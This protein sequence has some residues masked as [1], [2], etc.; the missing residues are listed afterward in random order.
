MPEVTA[1]R[2]NWPVGQRVARK[3]SEDHGTVT[4]QNGQIR[5]RWDD[6]RTSYFRH[7]RMANVQLEKIDD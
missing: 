1:D 5:V 3:D 6:G 7:G 4:E 2:T